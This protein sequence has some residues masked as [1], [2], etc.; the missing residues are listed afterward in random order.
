MIY[1]HNVPL[2]RNEN[3]ELLDKFMSCDF[4]TCPAVNRTFAKFIFSGKNINNKM[5]VRIKRIISLAV[6]ENPDINILGA[7]G[8]G[9]FGN[10]RETIYKIFEDTINAYIPDNIKVI[11]AVV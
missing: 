1:S 3:G 7:F 10:K 5:S 9:A 11:F 2:I 4:I 8:C 6:S